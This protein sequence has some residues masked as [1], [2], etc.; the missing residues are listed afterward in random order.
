VPAERLLVYRVDDGWEPLCGFLGVEVP[1][2]PFPRVNVG[3]DL[4][5]NIRLAM[6]L[7]TTPT[8]NVVWR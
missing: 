2:E 8:G 1:D 5:H 3:G 6:R 4:L 7:A